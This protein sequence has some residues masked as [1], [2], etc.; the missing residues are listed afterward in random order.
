MEDGSGCVVYV[1]VASPCSL[2]SFTHTLGVFSSVEKAQQFKET[3][4][5]AERQRQTEINPFMVD[6]LVLSALN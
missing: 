5:T 4:L 6:E 3:Q 2:C 1:V